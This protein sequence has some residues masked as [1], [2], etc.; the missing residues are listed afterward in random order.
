L[1][2][3]ILKLK[4]GDY[5]VEVVSKWHYGK[6]EGDVP[7]EIIVFYAGIKGMPINIKKKISGIIF[8]AE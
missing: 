8:A 5:I 4:A 3:N 7:P 1:Q 2:N 6:N